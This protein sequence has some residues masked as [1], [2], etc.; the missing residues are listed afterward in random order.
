MDAPDAQDGE[1]GVTVVYAR[2]S[3]ADQKGD[4]DRQVARVTEWATSHGYAVDRVVREVGSAL[5][6]H[7]RRFMGLLADPGVSTILVEH[8]DRCA[9]FGVEHLEAALQSSGRELVIAYPCEVD[10]DLVRDMT[11]MLTS[12]CARLYG[13]RA[14]ANRAAAA[15]RAAAQSD[16]HPGV[17]QS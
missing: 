1:A 2:V 4:L 5:N 14:A 3:S 7:R 8:R 13:K 15:L 16:E 6:G 12:F 9:R 10:D 11:E 17:Q